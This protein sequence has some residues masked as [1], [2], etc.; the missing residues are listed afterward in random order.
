MNPDHQTQ[1]ARLRTRYTYTDGPIVFIA[2]QVQRHLQQSGWHIPDPISQLQS[3][4]IGPLQTSAKLAAD[5]QAS[6]AVVCERFNTEVMYSLGT[7]RN[8]PCISFAP[9][10]PSLRRDAETDDEWFSRVLPV[11]WKQHLRSRLKGGQRSKK[12]AAGTPHKV[13]AA[14][15]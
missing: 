15:V 6:V 4:Q 9:D 3:V 13:E 1:V 2:Q 12:G 7:G 10:G 11:Q 8:G 5:A 14:P